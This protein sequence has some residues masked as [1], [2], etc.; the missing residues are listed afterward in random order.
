MS[1]PRDGEES[2]LD[3]LIK[4]IDSKEYNKRRKLLDSSEIPEENV[5]N[6]DI[7]NEDEDDYESELPLQYTENIKEKDQYNSYNEDYEKYI[8]ENKPDGTEITF[9]NPLFASYKLR[10]STPLLKYLMKLED[11]PDPITH[12]EKYHTA[13]PIAKRLQNLM[14]NK[15]N[16]D[17][18][19]TLK[20]NL[21]Y[22]YEC[23]NTYVDVFY[24][25]SR[26]SALNSVRFVYSLHIA[27]HIAKSAEKKKETG[28]EERCEGFTRPKVLI[29]CGLKCIAKEVID[30]MLKLIPGSKSNKNLERFRSDFSLPEEDIK[31]QVEGFM[32]TKKPVDFVKTFSG[33]Q[34]DAFKMGIRYDGGLLH[35]YSPFYSSDVIVAS[36]LGLR[37]LLSNKEP[38]YDFLSSIEVVIADRVDIIKFQNWR[39]FTDLMK[40]INRPLMKWRDGD[41]NKIRISA[42]DGQ[43][44]E[45]RQSVFISTSKNVVF[46][47]I[48]KNLKNRRGGLKLLTP[49]KSDYVLLASKFKIQQMFIKVPCTDV[50]TSREDCLDYF[51]ENMIPNLD[52]IKGVLI[53]IQDYTQ[54][55]RLAK[56]LKH[57]NLE[58]MACHESNTAKHMKMARQKFSTG[59]VPILVTT[60]RLLFFKRYI[61]KG[62]SKIFL[63]Q[64]P[65]Y[66]QLYKDFVKMAETNRS[67]TIV[68]YYTKYDGM[69]METIV[70]TQ[71]VAKLMEAPDTKIT[72]YH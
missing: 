70:G 15:K 37:P 57:A 61:L 26:V 36:P 18:V 11:V 22:L 14:K 58:F 27:N 64:P 4:V 21:K 34:E 51:M 25:N 3:K 17:D 30:N 2:N 1:P 10:Q 68:S 72:Q 45:Y 46:N 47:S 43:V 23:L 28:E 71:R 65:E 13:K 32:K 7:L 24:V 50:K 31:D 12:M 35:L 55:F 60:Y 49:S 54:Y 39:L 5:L 48:F 29:I 62:S 8:N 44:E 38:D 9:N 19:P 16:K 56:R 20:A 52:E 41:I 33:N 6:Y 66:A 63:I 40:V 67:N 69:L 42:I 59:E 53:V